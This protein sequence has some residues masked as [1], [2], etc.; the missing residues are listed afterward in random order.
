MELL[1]RDREA[2][3]RDDAR[4]AEKAREHSVADRVAQDFHRRVY[5]SGRAY[6]PWDRMDPSYRLSIRETVQFVVALVG[7]DAVAAALKEER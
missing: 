5:H 3:A 1:D 4:D 7:E 2:R 6:Y